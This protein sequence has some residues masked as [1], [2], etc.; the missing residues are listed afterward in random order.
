MEL[1]G[2]INAPALLPR[3]STPITTEQNRF[4]HFGKKKTNS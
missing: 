2:Q 4:G 3:E 1:S